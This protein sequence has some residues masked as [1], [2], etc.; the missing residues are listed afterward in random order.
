MNPQDPGPREN[1]N[2]HF[3]FFVPFVNRLETLAAVFWVIGAPP[4]APL[5]FCLCFLVIFTFLPFIGLPLMCIYFAWCIFIDD[6]PERGGRPWS[7]VR[8]WTVWKYF[9]DFF[10]AHLLK[11]ADLDPKKNY[12]FC[13]HPHG[14]LS[15]GCFLTFGTTALDFEKKYP[16][17][18]TRLL[19]LKMNFFWPFYREYLQCVGACDVSEK[20]CIYN[21][22]RA[23]GSSIV[24]VVG[25]ASEALDSCPGSNNLTLMKRRGFVRIALTTGA[26]LV[27]VFGFGENELYITADNTQ[28]TILRRVQERLLR[29]FGF[30]LPLFR[31]R[32]IFN[33]D[34]GLLPHRRPLNIVIGKGIDLPKIESPKKRRH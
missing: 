26:S 20:S 22:T 25:G 11:T 16:G 2:Q 27:P 3:S 33:Y 12:V 1:P 30:S 7:W 17:I 29:I 34:A 15:L 8:N 28:G 19:T 6:T 31:G 14:I 10:P 4:F 24:I 32:G 13:Y 23:P 9:R 5:F 18:S 21:L